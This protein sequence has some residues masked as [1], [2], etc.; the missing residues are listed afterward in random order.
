[1]QSCAVLHNCRKKRRL[2]CMLDKFHDLLR[3]R[4]KSITKPRTVLFQ[5]LQKSG[6]VPVSQFIRDN[7][8]VADRASLYRALIIFREVGVIED[9]IIRGKRMIEL[10]DVYDAHHHHLSCN[11]CNLSIAITLPD[12]EQQLVEL[13]RTYDF[14]VD[15]HVIEINGLC[16]T[17]QTKSLV[18]QLT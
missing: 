4:G 18:R 1:M 6:P 15:T 10:T 3:E 16:Q 14:E 8:G 2:G 12:I 7:V 13:C 5:Y 9:R 11:G 17:C